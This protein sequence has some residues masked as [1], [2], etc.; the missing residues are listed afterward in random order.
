M[1]FVLLGILNAQAA[2]GGGGIDPST[3]NPDLWLD[4]SDASTITESGGSVSQWDNKGTLSNFVQATS[5]NQPT[6]GANTLNGL[7][8]IDFAS[9]HLNATSTNEYKFLHDGTVY[10]FAFVGKGTDSNDL[11]LVWGTESDS[12][13]VIGQSF[14]I[15]DRSSA[16]RTGAVRYAISNGSSAVV[17]VIDNNQFPLNQFN[18]ASGLADP[19]NATAA[20]RLEYYLD[21]GTVRKEN[22]FTGTPSTSN[23]SE[24]MSIGS[25]RASGNLSG[26]IAE[27]IVVSGANATEEN[28][29]GIVEYLNNKWSVF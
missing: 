15:D 4:A 17:N 16:G 9:D 22:S 14:G 18:L 2:A 1:T 6:T 5:A 19:G 29:A 21:D 23:P 8:V 3:L 12:G 27:L 20:D 26:S 24:T 25:S 28:R 13:S 10:F 11:N 7:N